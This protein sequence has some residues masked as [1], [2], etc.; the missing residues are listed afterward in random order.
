MTKAAREDISDTVKILVQL[1]KQSL[2]L[3]DNG[4]RLLLARQ[5]M[6]KDES[7]Q[8]KPLAVTT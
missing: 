4:A 1:D 6:D 5:N 2:L 8:N 7:Q 3:I